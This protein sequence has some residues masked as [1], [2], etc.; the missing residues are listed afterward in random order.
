M[1]QF[2]RQIGERIRLAREDKKI[3]QDA[4]AAEFGCNDRQTV[5]AIETGLRQVKPEELTRISKILGEPLSF[6]TD[7]Y[8][9][10]EKRAFSYRAKPDSKDISAFEQRAHKLISANRRFRELLQEPASTFGNQLRNLNK[11]TSLSNATVCGE[12]TAKALGL[13]NVPALNL[14]DTIE[15]KLNVMVLFVEA[16]ES[17]SGAA[18]HL[19]DGDF[20]MINR[21]EAS[22][23]RNFDLGHEL[24]HILT[25]AEMPPDRIDAIQ[26]GES[27]PKVEKLADAFTA[28]LL[29][30]VEV[31]RVRWSRRNP[32]E[33]I[34]DWILQNA[35]DFRVS[36]QAL[37]WRL[38]NAQIISKPDAES[39]NLDLLSR[40]DDCEPDGKP[41]AYN[42][43][44]ARRV[45]AVLQR[46]LVSA[47]KTADLLEFDL[48]D[49]KEFLAAYKYPAPFAL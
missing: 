19:P 13:G 18:C 10:T 14:R 45:N 43:E 37:Y 21:N 7:P 47:R 41:N 46:G 28:G 11:Q 24:F 25:W 17:I 23:R 8:V 9:V 49:V 31:V 30:P 16:P 34:H 1:N 15:K 42:A 4:F 22:F 35:R 6:F 38:V 29:M 20:I 36:G 5:S 3:T 44:F 40:T 12:S 26:K 2:A 32:T 39:V 48:A 33:D 27:R